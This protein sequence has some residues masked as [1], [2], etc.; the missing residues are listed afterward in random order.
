V[1]LS[2]IG[3]LSLRSALLLP[4]TAPA[5]AVSR[6]PRALAGVFNFLPPSARPARPTPSAS[7]IAAWENAVRATAATRPAAGAVTGKFHE[8]RPG[9]LHTGID[10][11]GD[12]GEPVRA[13]FAGTVLVAG[14]APSGY[15]GY[16]TLVVIGHPNGLTTLYAHLSRV[17]AVVGR[18][19]A[20]GD[21][22]GAMGCTGSCTGPHLHFEVRIANIAV[23]PERYLP[24]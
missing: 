19:V 24:P 18:Q 8:R 14:R 23:D 15:G 6:A 1:F 11:H 22:V 16:G 3:L 2:L 7:E 5:T 4:A 13:A 10:I 20:S 21:V 12:T 9:H 17:S